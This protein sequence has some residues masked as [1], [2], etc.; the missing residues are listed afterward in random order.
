MIVVF[1]GGRDYR[2]VRMAEAIVDLLLCCEAGLGRDIKMRVGDCPTGLDSMV[3]AFPYHNIGKPWVAHWDAHGKAAG[4][5]R[6]GEMLRG[7]STFRDEG[8]ADLLIAFPGGKGTA[9]CVAQARSLGIAVIEV[10]A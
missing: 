6:N 4:P 1:T 8:V 7:K 2:N 3:S 5:V 10:P 9:D